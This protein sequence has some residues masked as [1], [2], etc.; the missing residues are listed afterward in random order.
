MGETLDALVRG[1]GRVRTP[2]SC[3]SCSA[4]GQR[5]TSL[6]FSDCFC[7][8]L[9][10]AAGCCGSPVT[11][12]TVV[13]V[14]VSETAAG[15]RVSVSRVGGFLPRLGT[16]RGRLRASSFPSVAGR[17]RPAGTAFPL[18]A[19]PPRAASE[20]RAGTRCHPSPHSQLLSW[21]SRLPQQTRRRLETR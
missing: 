8:A 17:S 19:N 15:L 2:S 11:S 20:G 6:I 16:H 9:E 1:S 10:R 5:R 4:R 13:S 3:C 12:H 21:C 18:H 14:S 7:I